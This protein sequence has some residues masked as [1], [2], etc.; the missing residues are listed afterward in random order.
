M[1]SCAPRV[2][3]TVELIYGVWLAVAPA[4]AAGEAGASSP[5]HEALVLVRVLGGR[6]ILQAALSP[7]RR[8]STGLAVGAG[9]DA[10]HAL[11]AV[12]AA[13]FADQRYRRALR[14][15]AGV[16]SAFAVAAALL[17]RRSRD[18]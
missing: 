3:D 10:A 6:H 2:L 15:D 4:R 16:A 18:G 12:L 1:Q 17:R 11:T 9:V 13:A 7:R 5:S 14:N 8:A